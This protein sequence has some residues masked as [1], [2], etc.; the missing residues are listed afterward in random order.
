MSAATVKKTSPA[1]AGDTRKHPG[2][3]TSPASVWLILSFILVFGVWEIAGRIPISPAF[4]PVSRVWLALL[5]LLANGELMAAYEKTLPPF[6]TGLAITSVVGVALG[7]IMGLSNISEWIFYPLLVILQTAPMAALIPLITLVYG[8]GFTAK[9]I[10]VVMLSLPMV[11]M[12][13]YHGIRNVS[14]T[15]LEMCRS[16][17]GSSSQQLFKI[18]LPHASGMIFASLRLGISGAFIG[19]VMAELLITPTGI[20]DII[21]YYGSVG[22]Y[23]NMFAAIVSI[24]LLATLVLT[25]VQFFERWIFDAIGQGASQ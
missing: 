13:C 24:I 10:A 23:P 4:P 1:A 9:V 7:V 14:P 22:I 8:V 17:M 25:V 21:S 16:F 3:R 5:E 20:G 2:R 15:L 12:N 11:T 18:I 19:I 6:L